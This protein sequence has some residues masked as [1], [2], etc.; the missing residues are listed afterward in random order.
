MLSQ[1]KIFEYDPNLSVSN[2]FVR[3]GVEQ[4][5]KV[6]FVF[7]KSSFIIYIEITGK[8]DSNTFIKEI[9]H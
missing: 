6:N 3:K 4:N 2:G 1:D 7:T 9:H 5:R 8:G